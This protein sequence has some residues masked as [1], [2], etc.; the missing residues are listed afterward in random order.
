MKQGTKAAIG[1]I[2]YPQLTEIQSVLLKR[3]SVRLCGE[4]RELM[5]FT[6]GFLLSIIDMNAL[7]GLLLDSSPEKIEEENTREITHETSQRFSEIDED[8]NGCEYHSEQRLPSSLISHIAISSWA[9]SR[10]RTSSN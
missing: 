1:S 8:G 6:N 10:L 4:M 7:V 3:G 9:F 2:F 5:L